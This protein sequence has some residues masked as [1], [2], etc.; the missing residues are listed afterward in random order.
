[1]DDSDLWT[2]DQLC[3]QVSAALAVDYTG[4]ENG[5]V[6]AVPDGRTIRW[7]TTTGLVDRPAAMRG[8]TAL[9]GRRHLA[10][11]VAIKRLQAQGLPLASIQ[12]ELTGATPETLERLAALPAGTP[13]P[14]AASQGAE[15]GRS[16]F[17]TAAPP[18]PAAF[19]SGSPGPV[20][21]GRTATADRDPASFPP[22]APDVGD[23]PSQPS[24]ALLPTLRLGPGVALMLLDSP[25]LPAPG[26]LASIQAAAAPLLD[27]LHRLGLD[28]PPHREDPR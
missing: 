22:S 5:R 9:Y 24:G 8:R 3:E 11:L 7:Y 16:R 28:G 15:P 23:R 1:M 21:A 6:R 27:V 18:P 25:R 4:A 20:P 17:W 12:R 10:Q 19:A 2:L 26:D 13:E 14:A